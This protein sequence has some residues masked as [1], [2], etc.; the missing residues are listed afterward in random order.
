LNIPEV[1]KIQ[2]TATPQH[3]CISEK[4]GYQTNRLCNSDS[5]LWFR[6]STYSSQTW[7]QIKALGISK[8]KT[9]QELD[10]DKDELNLKL[11][12]YQVPK[13]TTNT[14]LN[15]VPENICDTRF[16]FMCVDQWD[17]LD[18]ILKIKSNAIGPDDI[19][20]SFI[21]IILPILI[22]YPTYTFNT[23][24]TTSTFPDCW[25]TAKIILIPKANKEYRPI[26]FLPYLWKVFENIV[27][28][29]VNNFIS[30]NSLLNDHQSGFRK[31]RSCTSAIL[32]ITEDIRQQKDNS[33]V[34][35]LLLL[36]YCKAFDTVNHE[37]LC[38]KLKNL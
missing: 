2:N 12:E 26:S 10:V 33:Y 29:Q 28:S 13:V 34:T 37:I 19:H 4:N 14:Y 31:N 8:Q 5:E 7:K 27:A 25:K 17:V 15:S 3:V 22:P 24:L 9:S 32:K 20:P 16:R 23:A 1:E 18:N 11:A 21:K 6:N 35:F 38:S 30:V 36:D